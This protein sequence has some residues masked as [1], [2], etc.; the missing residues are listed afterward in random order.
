[1]D[2]RFGTLTAPL[3][4]APGIYDIAI[5][6]ANAETPGSNS[7]VIEAA[8][9]LSALSNVSIVAHLSETGAPTASV[10]DNDD[11]NCYPQSPPLF[12]H[13]VANA[14]DVDVRVRTPFLDGYR[15]YNALSDVV[16]GQ[17]GVIESMAGDM[18]INISPA[19]TKHPIVAHAKLNIDTLKTPYLYVVGSLENDTLTI[20]QQ[21]KPLYKN[22]EQLAL[23]L[24]TS[25]PYAG[26]FDTLL[27]A[28]LNADPVVLAALAG[29]EPITVFAPTDDAFAA[30]DLT[31]ETIANLG[32]SLLTDILLY[33]VAKGK[34]LA[35]EVL[36]TSSITMLKGGNLLQNNGVLTDNLGRSANIIITD[37]EA[38]NGVIHVI[39]TVVLPQAP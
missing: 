38:G 1:T 39:D 33:H 7:P 37:V 34:Q 32:Q 10:F 9:T 4:L 19:G 12:V 16:N 25:G 28:V 21:D 24:N 5:A 30:L 2:F 11:L 20:L 23:A 35:A 31:P 27:T 14:P 22:L 29:D 15:S 13:H 26:V 36:A 18:W 17:Q 3:S 8:V 6:P